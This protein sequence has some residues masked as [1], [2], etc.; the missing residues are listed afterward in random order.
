MVMI[1]R[2]RRDLNSRVTGTPDFKS[3]AIPGYATTALLEGGG[4]PLFPL[5]LGQC[6][7]MFFFTRCIDDSNMCRISADF[8]ADKVIAR[9]EGGDLKCA[10]YAPHLNKRLPKP[11]SELSCEEFQAVSWTDMGGHV[12]KA[13]V[14]LSWLGPTCCGSAAQARCMDTSNMCENSADFTIDLVDIGSN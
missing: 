10:S 7:K 4:F 8:K 3:G 13:P 2:S 11:W 1:W 6:L 9:A 12:A 5:S 14:L